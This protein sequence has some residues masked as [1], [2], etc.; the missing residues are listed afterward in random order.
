[1]NSGTLLLHIT[2]YGAIWM[3]LLW[4]WQVIRRDATIVDVGWSVGMVG[5]AVYLGIH[6]PGDPVRRLVFALLAAVWAARLGGYLFFTRVYRHGQE[7]GRYQRMR[8]AM[9]SR[10]HLG[11]FAFFHAQ[12]LFITLFSVPLL[13]P[14]ANPRTFPSP[15]DLIGILVWIGAM[16]GEWTADRQLHR[17]ITNPANKG[18]TCRI[19]LWNRSRHPNYFF[20]WLHWFAYIFLAMGSPLI[21]ASLA[22]PVIMFLFLFFITGIPHTEKQALSHRADYAEYM[23]EVPMF[24]PRL[25]TG[26]SS[27]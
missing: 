11:F 25:F 16:A 18:K 26:R 3:T 8:A 4:I 1:M 22:G 10:A 2:L 12:T 13:G 23:K 17:F 9:G 6:G 24:F 21:W 27:S 5:A 20:E 19:G 15:W 14:A 7:D